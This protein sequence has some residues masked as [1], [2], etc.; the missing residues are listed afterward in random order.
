[1]PSK[2]YDSL[3][4]MLLG[5]FH[6]LRIRHEY[7]ECRPSECPVC[8]LRS[9][10]IQMARIIKFF[11][12]LDVFGSHFSSG[13]SAIIFDWTGICMNYS[14]LFARIMCVAFAYFN[15]QKY[16]TNYFMLQ[17]HKKENEFVTNGWHV[18]IQHFENVWIQITAWV[19]CSYKNPF[20]VCTGTPSFFLPLCFLLPP[21]HNTKIL[22]S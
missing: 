17:L 15:Y 9:N 18:W 5:S 19:F 2:L 22:Y 3:C 12:S 4:I 7:N 8:K 13:N 14:N 1:M 21:F 20:W 6:K 11:K 10:A 16:I